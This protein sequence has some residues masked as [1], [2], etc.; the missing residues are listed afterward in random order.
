MALQKKELTYYHKSPF[1]LESGKHIDNLALHYTTYGQ[2]NKHKNNII[3]IIHALTANADPIA[4]WPGIVGQSCVIDPKKHFIICI[5]C[6][7]S[8]YGSTNP[9][10]ISPTTNS[11]YYHD[12][13]ICTIRDIARAYLLVFAHLGI[14]KINVL[15]GA[16]MGGQQ[17]Q[18]IAIM[19][20][21]L[22]E[23]LILIATNAQ[24]SP[25]GKA[26]NESQR[27]AIESDNTWRQSVPEAGS[28]GLKVARSIALLSYRT[29]YGYNTTQKDDDE[30]LH[31]YKASSYQRYQGQKLAERFN[32]FSYYRLTQA[33]DSHNVARYRKSLAHALSHIKATSTVVSI[34]TDV[35]FPPEEQFL[36]ANMIPNAQLVS[37]HSA[38]GHDGFLTETTSMSKIIDT[39]LQS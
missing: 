39:V 18:E 8:P 28:H 13:P 30:V 32:A 16:S 22:V 5:N 33:M 2:L 34:T 9:L 29:P 36:L 26:F 14:N 35:L 24:H 25:W 3:W 15:I 27:M 31:D 6:L 11:P 17:A 19:Q 20:P 23:K 10:S 38:L 37:I 1:Y 4:W 12:F 21:H 7:G